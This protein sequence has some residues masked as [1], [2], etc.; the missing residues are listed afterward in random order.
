MSK[1]EREKVK[2][3]EKNRPLKERISNIWGTERKKERGKR[4][5]KSET[6]YFAKLQLER[7]I[8]PKREKEK[9]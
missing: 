8:N 1:R 5:R 3:R 4:E 7:K 2:E 6:Q 9:I